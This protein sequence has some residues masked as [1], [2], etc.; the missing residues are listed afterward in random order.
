MCRSRC[1]RIRMR[2]VAAAMELWLLHWRNE[3]LVVVAHVG[4]TKDSLLPLILGCTLR[5]N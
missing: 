1:K 4:S 2:R 5:M 3:L